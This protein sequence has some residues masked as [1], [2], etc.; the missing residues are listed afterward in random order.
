MNCLIGKFV[1]VDSGEAYRTGE[2]VASVDGHFY[3]VRF[4]NLTQKT[5]KLPASTTLMCLHEMSSA[6]DSDGLEIKSWS[7]F[8]TRADLQAFINWLDAP[9][10]SEV[11]KLVKPSKAR[12]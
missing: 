11:V 12:H 6:Y 9:E 2:I 7:F 1:L 10:K 8:D 3:L 4:D 5:E